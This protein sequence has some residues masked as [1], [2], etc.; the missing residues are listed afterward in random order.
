M[1]DFLATVAAELGGP[2]GALV[3]R[4]AS[5]DASDSAAAIAAVCDEMYGRAVE[6]LL[7]DTVSPNVLQAGIKANVIP[8]IAEIQV[9]CRPLPGT[10][11]AAMRAELRRRIGEELWAVCDVELMRAGAPVEA[12]RDNRLYR[13]LE[14]TLKDHD[15]EGVPVPVMV[16]FATDAK[17]TVRLDVPTYGFSPLRLDPDERFLDRFHGTDERVAVD[18]LRFGLPVLYDVVR[19]FCG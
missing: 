1:A 18:A 11:E 7:R 12:T 8:G 19:R 14:S 2:T 9:D 3:R 16:P 5:A 10:D 13:T 15:P 17:H 4:I 6:A